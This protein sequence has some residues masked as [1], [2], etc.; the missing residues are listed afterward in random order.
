[1]NEEMIDILWRR[2]YYEDETTDIIT[3]IGDR[4]KVEFRDSV[5]LYCDDKFIKVLTGDK[6]EEEIKRYEFLFKSDVE[7]M[8]TSLHLMENRIM[9]RLGKIEDKQEEMYEN[10]IN[11]ISYIKR[12]LSIIV[13]A[14]NT[15]DYIEECLDSIEG[16]SYFLNNDDYEILVGVDNCSKT[17]E[18]LESIKHKYRNLKIYMMDSN[19][20]TYVTTNTLI[21]LTTNDNILRFDSDDIMYSNMVKLIMK[22]FFISDVVRMCYTNFKNGVDADNPK[23]QADGVILFDKNILKK[24]GGYKAWKCAADS[25]FNYRIKRDKTIDVK[26]ID[27]ALFRRRIHDDSLTRAIG[28]A[29][30]SDLREQYKEEIRQIRLNNILYVE[31][32][33]NSYVCK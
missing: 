10:Y 21:D 1:M 9:E 22:E 15:A 32:E 18:K 19:K 28:T 5:L 27:R 29:M 20:G 11:A 30:K 4:I 12:S 26:L 6:F 23:K 3:F 31:K 16:Q 8:K 7:K 2:G 25:D 33:T 17:L 14:Y 13:T 24:F